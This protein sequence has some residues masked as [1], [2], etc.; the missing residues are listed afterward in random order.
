[1]GRICQPKSWEPGEMI[2]SAVAQHARPRRREHAGP[3]RGNTDRASASS[4]RR[5]DGRRVLQVRAVQP[6]WIAEG[7]HRAVDD[8]GRRARG[9]HPT[10][11]IGDRRAD[12]GQHRRRAWRVVAAAKGY[13]LILDDARQHVAGAAGAAAR[14]RR[15]GA[16]D[17]GGAGHEGRGRT[18]AR[19]LPRATPRRS[20]R[21]SSR[22][23]PTSTR[24]CARPAPRSSPSSATAS[25]T[26]S[27]TASARAA[28]SPASGRVLR[29]KRPDVRIVA[30][31]P[32]K[33][34]VLS[35]GPAGEH[36]IDGIGAG[37]VPGDPRPLGAQRGAHHLRAGRA[38]DE[39]AAR[40]C[41]RGCWSASRRARR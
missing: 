8:R 16:P 17:A 26:R 22:T 39:A 20:C 13:R 23:R 40:R 18:R 36:R 10:G 37:F 33:S 32:E 35:G 6:R 5:V 34:A 29:A 24:T 41:A 9:A 28:P 30:V 1:M 4:G 19:D 2:S 11:R 21:C 7:S 15:R 3:D 14:L 27:S 12:L 25:P 38:E 31:E